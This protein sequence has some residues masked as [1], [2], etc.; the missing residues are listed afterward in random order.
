M[1]VWQDGR[2]AR[3]AVAVAAATLPL[4]GGQEGS[5]LR[6]ACLP[7]PFCRWRRRGALWRR[8]YGAQPTPRRNWMSC[9][10]T[11]A[12]TELW[13]RRECWH[14]CCEPS[15]IW[16]C[17]RVL[18]VMASLFSC[19]LSAPSLGSACVLLARPFQPACCTLNTAWLGASLG[20]PTHA[21][22][23]RGSRARLAPPLA[24]TSCSPRAP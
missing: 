21:H 20:V 5:L 23:P 7:F 8:S 17:K 6:S 2:N 14:H 10:R 4:P 13:A 3:A 22:P 12:H 19:A 16:P 1:S 9:R 11:W 18:L 15:L 24:G